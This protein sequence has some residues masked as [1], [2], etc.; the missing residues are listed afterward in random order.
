MAESLAVD[1]R[2]SLGWLFQDALTLSTVA[3]AAKLDYAASLGGAA[4]NEPADL[5]WHDERTLAAGAS[6]NLTLSA[7]TTT[8]FGGE[9]EYAFGVVKGLL[10]VN[11]ADEAGGDLWIGGAA[12]DAWDAP[13]DAADN[14]AMVPAGSC[15]LWLNKLVGWSVAAGSAD[16]LKIANAGS[17]ATTY[18]IVVFGER[19]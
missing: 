15:L 4:E 3:D 14:R 11:L 13:F 19:E 7:L 2:A 6:E 9:V 1:V 16:V 12:A 5:L 8:L 10:V 17:A 18:R